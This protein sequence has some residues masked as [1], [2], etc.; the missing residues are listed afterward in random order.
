[1][2]KIL[3]KIIHWINPNYFPTKSYAE[4]DIWGIE[5]IVEGKLYFS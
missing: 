5:D 4:L 2:K 1:M 3:V